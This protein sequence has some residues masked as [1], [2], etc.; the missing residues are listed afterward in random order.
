MESIMEIFTKRHSLISTLLILILCQT[1]IFCKST[2]SLIDKVENGILPHVLI[3]NEP[4]YK[5]ADR[6]KHYHVPGISITVIKDYEIAWSKQYGV[7]DAELQNPVDEKTLF[8]VGSLSKGVASLAALSLVEKGKIDLDKDVN[9]QLISWK[10]PENELMKNAKVTPLLLMNHSSGAMFSPPYSYLEE[11]LPTLQQVLNG[12]KPSKSGPVVIDKIPGTVYQYS[13]AGYLILQQLT[14][15][16]GKKSYCD[17]TKENIFEPLHMNTTSF[18]QP[19]PPYFLEHAS[20]GH[21]KNGEAFPDKRYLYPHMAAGGLWT[22]A[23]DYANYI[24]ELQKSYHN[25]SNKIISQN[26]TKKM[27]SPHV[28]KQY[29]LG[30]FMREK[31][32]EINYFGHLGDNRGFFAGFI[33]H[34]TDGYGAV[35]F[36]NSQNGAQLIREIFHG[37]AK[38]YEWE[39][40]LPE[41]HK[42][43]ELDNITAK[44]ICG[45]YRI[46]ADHSFEIYQKGEDL[47]INK[48]DGVK[49]FH[50]GEGKFVLKPRDGSLQI[51]I[52]DNNFSSGTYQFTDELGRFMYDPQ[53]IYKMEKNEKLPGE[54][55]KLGKIKE[56]VALYQKCKKENPKD[57][58]LSENQLNRMGYNYIGKQKYNEAIAIMKL[59][60]EFYPESAN[61]YDSLGEAY[62][63]NG[64]TKL[65][66]TNYKKSLKLNPSNQNAVM[67][68]QQLEKQF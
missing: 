27:L 55:M 41:E 49:L 63:K 5:L 18:E 46:G 26:L 44:K 39:K 22:T 6:M 40:Y 24:I 13:N 53:N 20:A 14:I 3:E 52:K 4:G 23:N 7:M 65:A 43:V 58:G 2:E 45:R 31:D 16:T 9:E 68:L 56:S 1:S 60:V 11:N 50:I 54:L 57:I 51:L 30:V 64:Q 48:F 32:G 62:M 8:N 10:I 12:E 38:V 67:K 28:S 59:N 37:I 42:I 21:M 61:C 29:G 36:T 33:S 17:F 47:F 34:M 35:A 25:K 19:L 15:D 66:I